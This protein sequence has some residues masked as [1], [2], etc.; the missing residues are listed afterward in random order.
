M[1][2]YFYKELSPLTKRGCTITIH[3]PSNSPRREKENYYHLP[4]K[5]KIKTLQGKTC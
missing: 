5:L 1:K 2:M 4:S 3:K